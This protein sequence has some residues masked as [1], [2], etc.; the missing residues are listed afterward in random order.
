MAAT[1]VLHQERL[2]ALVCLLSQLTE[3][4]HSLQSYILEVELGAQR[5]VGVGGQQ[6]HVVQVADGGG[7]CLDGIILTNLGAHG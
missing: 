4:A 1:L 3:V 7:L 5:K 2:G 6:M